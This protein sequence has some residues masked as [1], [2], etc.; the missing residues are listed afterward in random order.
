[1]EAPTGDTL[2]ATTPALSGR[3]PP[4][5]PPPEPEIAARP[6]PRPAII[7][8]DVH[9]ELDSIKDLY[10]YLSQRWRTHLDTF[11][12]R[13]PNSGYYPRFMDNREEAPPPPGPP[14]GSP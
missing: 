3:D 9:N 11:G 14:A 10:P 4:D 2:P 5:P 12:V 8:C 13:S 7:D 6:R 1:M